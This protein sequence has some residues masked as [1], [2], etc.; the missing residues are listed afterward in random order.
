MPGRLIAKRTGRAPQDIA[1]RTFAATYVGISMSMLM[2]VAKQPGASI[3]NYA[4]LLD[5]ALSSLEEGLLQ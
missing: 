2:E 1:V 5:T 3:K 4:Q